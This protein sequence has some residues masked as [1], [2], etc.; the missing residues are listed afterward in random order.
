MNRSLSR[1]WSLH[2]LAI[3]AHT[4]QSQQGQQS[5]QAMPALQ[6][7]HHRQRHMDNAMRTLEQARLTVS[8]SRTVPL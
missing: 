8:S 2:R 3:A 7:P 4:Q 1:H 5:P 6:A